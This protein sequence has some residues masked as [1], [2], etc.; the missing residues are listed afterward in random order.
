[1]VEASEHFLGNADLNLVTVFRLS[2]AIGNLL[3][4]VLISGIV[5]N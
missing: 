1:L 2:S 5:A 4:P 3:V